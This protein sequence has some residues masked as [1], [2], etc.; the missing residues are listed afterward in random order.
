[1]KKYNYLQAIYM[2]FYSKQLYRD[3]AENWGAGVVLYLFMLLFFCMCVLALFIQPQINV[4]VKAGLDNI[5]PQVPELDIKNGVITTP[6]KKPYLIKESNTSDKVI[7]IVDTSGQYTSLDNVPSSARTLITDTK[8]YYSDKPNTVKVYKLP[9]NLTYDFK[10]ETAKAPIITFVKWLWVIYIPLMLFGMFIYRLV[11][12]LIYAVFGKIFALIGGVKLYYSQ[13]LKL[14]IIALTPP[15]ILHLIV[16]MILNLRFAHEL[17][18]YFIFAMAYLI[19][20]IS[21]NKK[22]QQ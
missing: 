3:V 13:V 1:M 21:A 20:A 10:P 9:N 15:I 18:A 2:S 14:T 4:A 5:L 11:Q 12:S 7:V 19:F 22:V 8:V 6:E 16:S 17:L